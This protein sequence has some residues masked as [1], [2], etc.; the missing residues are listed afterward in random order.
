MKNQLKKSFSYCID[1]SLIPA[2]EAHKKWQISLLV[3]YNTTQDGRLEI[4]GL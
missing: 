4:I 3:G 2:F 1:L